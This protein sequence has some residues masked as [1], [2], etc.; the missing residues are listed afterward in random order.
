MRDHRRTAPARRAAPRRR[1]GA[2]DRRVSW[3]LR[4]RARAA[5]WAGATAATLRRAAGRGTAGRTY[6]EPRKH[7]NAHWDDVRRPAADMLAARASRRADPSFFPA[8]GSVRREP[9]LG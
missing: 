5:P 6:P 2:S 1:A 3:R 8:D 7:P 4:P 9:L